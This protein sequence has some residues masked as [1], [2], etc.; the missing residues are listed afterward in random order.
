MVTSTA[1]TSSWRSAPIAPGLW[2][3]FVPGS[4]MAR[5]RTS[6]R[7]RVSVVIDPPVRVMTPS[8]SASLT[9]SR[10]TITVAALSTVRFFARRTSQ[11]LAPE[12]A[13][14]WVDLVSVPP[15]IRMSSAGA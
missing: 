15:R 4:V 1:W 2:V 3:R 14:V 13:Q 9:S 12:A 10:P 7:S 8:G 11:A 5:R 6:I